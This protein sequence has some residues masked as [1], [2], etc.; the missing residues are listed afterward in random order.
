MPVERERTARDLDIDLAL[1]LRRGLLLQVRALERRYSL[2]PSCPECKARE[3][4]RDRPAM[5]NQRRAG[6]G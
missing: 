1:A 5:T 4:G 6:Y 3:Q 2:P